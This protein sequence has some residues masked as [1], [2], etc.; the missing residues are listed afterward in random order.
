MPKEPL[1]I[2]QIPDFETKRLDAST[3]YYSRLGRHLHTHR[4]IQRPH[5]H[6]FY[7]LLLFT[8]GSGTHS[9]D[10]HSYPV[11]AGATF[12]LAPGEVHSWQLSEDS[13]GHILFFS[14]AFYSFGFPSKKLLQFPFFSS[15]ERSHLLVLDPEDQAKIERL[16]EALELE[17][18]S[19]S[20]AKKEMIRSQLEVL[21]IALGRAYQ[22]IHGLGM[23]SHP[24]QDRSKL[25]EAAIESHFRSKHQPSFY[26]DLLSLSLKQLNRLSKASSGKTLSQLIL[27]RV[28]LEAQRLLSYSDG[29]VAEIAGQ[30]GFDDP[31]YFSRFFRKK[32]GNTPEQFRKAAR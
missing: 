21:L 9:I 29:T 3:F 28:I 15:S 1:P 6:D 18:E 25:L 19:T 32:T 8:A 10:V 24:V 20:W 2:Y 11:E 16:F 12:F 17:S 13:E 23:D 22:A 7:I 14:S 26:A 4:F 5:K 30:L 27:D 31:S